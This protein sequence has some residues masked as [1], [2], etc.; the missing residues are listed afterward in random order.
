MSKLANSFAL[1]L[2]AMLVSVRFA[3]AAEEKLV[4]PILRYAV[5]QKEN[6]DAQYIGGAYGKYAGKLND[7]P[8]AKGPMIVDCLYLARIGL[9]LE[10]RGVGHRTYGANRKYHFRW[11]HSEYPGQALK[12]KR[13]E[14]NYRSKQIQ[15]DVKFDGSHAHWLVNGTVIATVAVEKN[16][17]FETEFKLQNC[18]ANKFRSSTMPSGLFVEPTEPQ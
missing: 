10:P 1:S 12:R 2:F 6:V 14:P 7:A 4:Y 17:R 18:A 3:V 8:V 9:A 16:I 5:S 11:T 15:D 13:F